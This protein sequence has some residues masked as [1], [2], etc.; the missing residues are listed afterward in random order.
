[1]RYRRRLRSRIIISF[2]LFG[3]ALTGLFA[4]SAVYL[5]SYL[6]DKLIGEA[7]IRNVDDY[8]QKFHEDP[9]NE[10]LA[11]QKIVGYVFTERKIPNVP[12]AWRDL[13]NGV[14]DL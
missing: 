6:E 7:L 11:F 2:A 9:N 3:L 4:L 12:F 8:A 5:R 10:F 1:M 13:P 14:H